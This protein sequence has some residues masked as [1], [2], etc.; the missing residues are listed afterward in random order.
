MSSTKKLEVWIY[1]ILP[2]SHIVKLIYV[3]LGIK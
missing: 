1:D 3:N 2:N